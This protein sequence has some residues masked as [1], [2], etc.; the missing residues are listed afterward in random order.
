MNVIQHEILDRR[1]V[2]IEKDIEYM[3]YVST[4]F[5]NENSK[6]RLPVTTNKVGYH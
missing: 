6:D 1:S 5:Y 4:H 3:L 2:N